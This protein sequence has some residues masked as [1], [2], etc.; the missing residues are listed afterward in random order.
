MSLILPVAVLGVLG[1]LAFH[2]VR[3]VTRR[4]RIS[5]STLMEQPPPSK[6]PKNKLS[7]RHLVASPRFWLRMAAMVLVLVSIFPFA[8]ARQAQ[9]SAISAVRFVVDLSPS[10]GVGTRLADAQAAFRDALTAIDE[11]VEESATCVEV[12]LVASAGATQ[13]L[14]SSN[15]DGDVF[16]V[17]RDGVPAAQLIDA[18][19]LPGPCARPVSHAILVTDQAPRDIETGQFSGVMI[20]HQLGQPETNVALTELRLSGGGLTGQEARVQIQ[21]EAFGEQPAALSVEVTHPGGSD[22]VPMRRDQ[23]GAGFWVGETA[24]L[25]AGLYSARLVDPQAL[26]GDDRLSVELSAE[27][28]IGIDWRLSS[29]APTRL[30]VLG[31]EQGGVLVAPLGSVSMSPSGRYILAYDFVSIP[32]SRIGIFIEDHPLLQNL[33]F[34]VLERAGPDAPALPPNVVPEH[35]AVISGE[36]GPW[37][38]ASGDGRGAIVPFAP[39]GGTD[40]AQLSYLV[41]ANALRYVTAEDVAP[42]AQH[43]DP[44]GDPIARIL[45]EADTARPLADPPNYALLLASSP[46]APQVTLAGIEPR[47]PLAPVLF[48]LALLA[49][50]LDRMVGP[51]W[52]RRVRYDL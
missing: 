41:L 49:L 21:A 48:A 29:P 16:V 35:V 33:N 38:L 7:L 26:A 30:P 11:T 1:V 12:A 52:S 39:D 3:P 46:S 23:G 34:D 50:L 18:L 15:V 27:S 40:I 37:I 31:S 24:F 6:S 51:V 43:L 20:W 2:M 14:N 5:M 9:H 10:M 8:T 25:Q 44:D 4:L 47:V 19:R 36:G 42:R 32:D 17:G 13:I 22:V 45:L 28:S